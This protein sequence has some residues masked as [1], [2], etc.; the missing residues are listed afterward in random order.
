[1][2]KCAHAAWRREV[3]RQSQEAQRARAS[4]VRSLLE[5]SRLEPDDPH[6]WHAEAG[7]VWTP[8]QPESAQRTRTERFLEWLRGLCR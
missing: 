5:R 8:L 1:M 4:V 3:L 6:P 7:L 2:P